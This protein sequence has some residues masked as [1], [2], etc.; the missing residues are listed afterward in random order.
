M[1]AHVPDFCPTCA[2]AVAAMQAEL[3]RYR[4]QQGEGMG[5]G[6]AARLQ[7]RI[8]VLERYLSLKPHA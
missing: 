5:A 8:E 7:G 4:H 1:G 6:S 3:K 2:G